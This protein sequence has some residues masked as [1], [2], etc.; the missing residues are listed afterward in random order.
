MNRCRRF[1]ENFTTVPYLPIAAWVAFI[2]WTS[3]LSG[4]IRPEGGHTL[5]EWLLMA[6][7]LAFAIGG[8][9]AVW[10]GSTA[11]TRAESSGL[12]LLTTGLVFYGVVVLSTGVH[13]PVGTALSVTAFTAMCLIRMRI[14]SR[15]RKAQEAAEAVRR[16]RL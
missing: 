1:W 3:L 13:D 14:L 8:T 6:W 16:G 12:A 7:T 5:P 4:G 10:G 9:L 11:R 15:A 2:G